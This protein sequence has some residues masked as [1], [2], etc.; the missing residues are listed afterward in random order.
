M[1]WAAEQL[2]DLHF[3]ENTGKVPVFN[4]DVRTFEVTNKPRPARSS[5]CGTSTP[6]PARASGRAP[7]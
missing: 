2:Y 5:A 3:E 4:P 6:S 1:H 7:G